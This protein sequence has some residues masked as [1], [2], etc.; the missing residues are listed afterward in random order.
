MD[1]NKLQSEGIIA[2]YKPKGLTSHDIVNKVRQITGVR[3]V[4]HA[5]TLDPLA[6]GVLVIAVG[7]AFTK[8]L[9]KI[10]TKEKEYTA[11]ITLG[12]T[13]TTDDAEG[14]IES[15]VIDAVPTLEAVIKTVSSFQG[16][17]LQLPPNY[18]AIKIKGK[19]AYSLIRAGKKPNLK[20]REV[21]IKS[22]RI[23][24][25][26]W[27]ILKLSVLTGPG[28]YIRSL[29][30]D[31]GAELKVGGYVSSL[32]RTRVGEHDIGRAVRLPL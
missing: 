23:I 13:S 4:G 6:D 30:R 7:R 27:P 11:E 26:A 19:P 28:V 17:V 16:R 32:T 8:T 5:G 29:A 31:I 24:N 14:P 9:Q 21:E 20:P 15:Q 12:K 22:I 2:V 3:C 10:V 18:S 25:Y 1:L